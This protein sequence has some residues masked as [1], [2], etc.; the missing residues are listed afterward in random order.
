[1][2]FSS[3]VANA[4]S[5]IPTEDDIQTYKTAILNDYD[6]GGNQLKI[7]VEQYFI[8]AWTNGVEVY[9]TYRRTGEPNDLTPAL[10]VEN[11]G[12][13]I[14]SHWYPSNSVDRN[15]NVNQKSSLGIPVFWDTNPEG[16][17]Q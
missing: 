8:A 1:M 15:S 10:D 13:F 14:R 17:V 3:S 6:T 2:S 4:S 5:F 11:P 7:I 12:V 9:N 16:F